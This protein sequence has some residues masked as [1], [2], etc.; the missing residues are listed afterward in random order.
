MLGDRE[1]IMA[2]GCNGYFE[3]PIDPLTFVD[4]IHELLGAMP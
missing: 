1:K 2:A 4:R 3:K